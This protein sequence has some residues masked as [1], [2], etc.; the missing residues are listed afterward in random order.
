MGRKT[1]EGSSADQGYDPYDFDEDEQEEVVV[2]TTR[3]KPR[4]RKS[5]EAMET[6]ASSAVPAVMKLTEERLQIFRSTLQAVFSEKHAQSLPLTKVTDRL[7]K[8][9][10]DALFSK[11]E[12][13]QAVEKM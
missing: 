6:E 7:N 11:S 10:P 5:D 12:V 9:Y 13:D 2:K 8:D 3:R 1:K 4:Q